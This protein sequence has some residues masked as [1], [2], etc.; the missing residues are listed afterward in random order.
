[1]QVR[2]GGPEEAEGAGQS[3][4]GQEKRGA[5]REKKHLPAGGRRAER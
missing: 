4:Q 2:Q 3:Q 1:M 5:R